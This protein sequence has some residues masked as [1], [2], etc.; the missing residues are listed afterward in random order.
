[1]SV[2]FDHCF[3]KNNSWLS[4][5]SLTFRKGCFG[6]G[7]SVGVR[8][9]K[10]WCSFAVHAFFFFLFIFCTDWSK[11]ISVLIH[12]TIFSSHLFYTLLGAC[13]TPW[14]SPRSTFPGFS[15]HLRAHSTCPA[16]IISTCSITLCIHCLPFPCQTLQDALLSS[17][18]VHTIVFQK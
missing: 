9:L 5:R 12:T 15:Q 4:G 14:Q 2:C 11:S 10:S 17:I 7:P 3:H 13:D 16:P 18:L 8:L 1:M 6:L